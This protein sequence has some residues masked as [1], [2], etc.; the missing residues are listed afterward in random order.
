MSLLIE[1]D[2][3]L[4]HTDTAPTRFGR[5]A[6][7]DPRFVFDLRRGRECGP[8]LRA[9]VEAYMARADSRPTRNG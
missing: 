7:N 8:K 1:I 9:R 3:Y 2:R 6:A 4:R 5:D